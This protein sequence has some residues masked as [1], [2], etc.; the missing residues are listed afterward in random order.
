MTAI[1]RPDVLP[2]DPK[3]RDRM[4]WGNADTQLKVHWRGYKTGI[5][6]RNVYQY[7]ALCPSMPPGNEKGRKR[8]KQVYGTL[9][10]AT[11]CD[12]GG[13][14]YVD[15]DSGNYVLA[16]AYQVEVE[17]MKKFKWVDINKVASKLVNGVYGFSK[18]DIGDVTCRLLFTD[19]Q[20]TAGI[21]I[22]VD[23]DE[24]EAKFGLFEV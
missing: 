13:D 4:R 5:G 12:G 1:T 6:G 16:P 24:N 23:N 14:F 2:D 20:M 9:Y 22:G 15:V 21:A 19:P 18:V 17:A 10:V 8:L 3:E 11:R 7:S